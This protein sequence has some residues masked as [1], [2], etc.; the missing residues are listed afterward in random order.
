[1]GTKLKAA[2]VERNGPIGILK[3]HPVERMMER[4]LEPDCEEF[5]EIHHSMSIGLDELR[6]DD[7]IRAIIITG[8]AEDVFYS[9][10]LRSHYDVPKYR[11][12]L[13]GIISPELNA[14]T[15]PSETR[16]K[17][18]KVAHYVDQLL[19]CEKPII[20]RVNGDV[21]GAGQSVM[22]GCDII[23]ARD[24]AVV[25]DVHTGMGEVINS[26]GEPTGFPWAVSPGDGAMAF[27]QSNFPSSYIYKE[28]QLLSRQYTAR[29]LADMHIINYAFPTIDEVDAKV[30]EIVRRLLARPASVLAH[31]RRLAQ[32][33]IIEQANLQYDLSWAFEHQEFTQHG[34]QGNFEAGW[35]PTL[36]ADIELP[37]EAVGRP[38]EPYTE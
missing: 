31:T 6:F 23:I 27:A 37:N 11:E 22:W 15:R 29:E 3:L 20:A 13:R 1:M 25:A 38:Q 4:S 10:P 26:K 35:A 16:A 28:Y 7:E 18:R 5:V 24:D 12:R 19:H 33:P 2:E 36:S 32:K 17:F 30:D 21:I 8:S 14:Q 9:A 34:L